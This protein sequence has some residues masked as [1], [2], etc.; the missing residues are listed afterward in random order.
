MIRQVPSTATNS[1]LSRY[2]YFGQ[3]G[4]F[5][6]SSYIH[7]SKKIMNNLILNVQNLIFSLNLQPISSTLKMGQYVP[8]KGLCQST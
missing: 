2:F 6:A 7:S 1:V 5:G 4:Y 3:N 8:P